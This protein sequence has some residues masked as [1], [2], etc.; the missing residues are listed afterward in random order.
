MPILNP[1]AEAICD[2][3][4]CGV[5]EELELLVADDVEAGE[6]FAVVEGTV[7]GL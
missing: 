4:E 2:A 5:E 3:D 6:L 1:C 7:G